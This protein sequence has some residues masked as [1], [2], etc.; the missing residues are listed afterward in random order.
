MLKHDVDVGNNG[1]PFYPRNTRF[2]GLMAHVRGLRRMRVIEG[3]GRV[4]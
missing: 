2:S 4:W 1:L 3:W